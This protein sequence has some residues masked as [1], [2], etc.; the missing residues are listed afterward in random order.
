[1]AFHDFLHARVP[2]HR[3]VAARPGERGGCFGVGVAELLGVDVMPTTPRE[4]GPVRGAEANPRSATQTIRRQ[5]QPA[6]SSFTV[7]MIEVS[8]VLPGSVQHRTGTPSRV[9]AMAITT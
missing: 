4:V 2:R 9:T 8:L 6:R 5:F 7:R 3:P 1:M